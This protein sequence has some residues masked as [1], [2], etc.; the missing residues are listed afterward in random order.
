MYRPASDQATDI[1]TIKAAL[2][3]GYPVIATVTEQSV[4]DLDLGTNPY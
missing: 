2:L 4:F 1:N 3:R